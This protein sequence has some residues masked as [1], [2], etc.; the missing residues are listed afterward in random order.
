MKLTWSALVVCTLFMLQVAG[1]QAP[2]PPAPS[3]TPANK[4][5]IKPGYQVELLYTVP[6]D[7]QG[8]WVCMCADPKGRLIVSD[9]YGG[10]FRVAPPLIGQNAP[11]VVEK[12][13][14]ELGEAQGLTWAFD[15]LYVVV[16]HAQKYRS[17][18]YR[19]RDTDGDDCLDKVEMLR[20]FDGSGEHGPHAVI[21]GPDGQSLYLVIGN[22]T[23]LTKVDTSR[24]PRRWAEDLIVP[25]MWDTKGHAHGILAPGGHIL[26]TDADGKKWELVSVGYRNCYDAAFDST[27]EL[28]TFDSDMEWDM[29]TPWYRAT[30][31]CHVTSGSEFGWRSGSGNWPAYYPDCLPATVDIG[32]GS[33]TGVAFGRQAKF[34]SKYQDALFI[35]DW[36]YG[37]LYAVH[38]RPAGATYAA[39]FEEF[40]GGVPLPMTDI[41][42]NSTD[43]AMYFTIGGR[44]TTSA[45]YRVTYV[46]NEPTTAVPPQVNRTA[47]R[48][49]REQLEA[50]H[51][52]ADPTAVDRAWPYLGHRDR[53]VR[54]AARAVLEHCDASVWQQRALDATEPLAAMTGL[55]ALA[56]CGSTEMQSGVLSALAK[57]SWEPLN[58][59]ERLELVRIYQL[60][61]LRLGPISP[62]SSTTI[63]ARFCPLFPHQSR[64]VNA[65][66]GKLL[67]YLH[68]PTLAAK[69]LQI[70]TKA[71]TQEEQM[72]YATMLRTVKAGWTPSL[73]REYFEWFHRAA[74]YRGGASF[75]GFVQMIKNEAMAQ[76][77]AEEKEALQDILSKKPEVAATVPIQRP[78][79]RK[80]TM[81][82]IT[83]GLDGAWRG[84]NY[85]R[86]RDLFDTTRCAVCHR[87]NGDGG[88]S[89]PDLTT[90]AGRF[91]SHD[92]LESIIEPSRVISDQYSAVNIV[93]NDGKV[94]H[95][96]IVNH[97]DDDLLIGTDM[98]VPSAVVRVN[99]NNIESMQ[100][101]RVSMMPDGLLDTCSL[102]E[103]KDLLAYMLSKG[104]LRHAI[105]KP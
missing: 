60:A 93:T 70:M 24:V 83:P 10:L 40:L 68:E 4:I 16:N 39:E 42:V 35:C 41:V 59:P 51:G 49:L 57:L 12:I 52:K 69:A 46:G 91:N 45:L 96:R 22:H 77:T 14:V 19:L 53:F 36:S 94:V 86:G 37:I 50:L 1:S 65:E 2:K 79:V 63:A 7:E 62:S 76:L 98:L 73:R 82:D 34:P 25:R 97:V 43:G 101:S 26:K 8:S 103:I 75:S 23:K 99:R 80:W 85:E 64:P 54:F 71:T 74:G 38:L 78:F 47:E 9:Q 72:E 20:E 44:K 102:D 18:L 105:F 87:F 55:L 48:L 32:P 104:D 66:I 15:S 88:A 95:G 100:T 56:R 6:R 58:E 5:R 81:A 61:L 11:V 3:A 33:P 90:V 84:R 31:V 30:R 67:A 27:G 92:L 29:N 28:F 17:G 13:P 21:P 89:G